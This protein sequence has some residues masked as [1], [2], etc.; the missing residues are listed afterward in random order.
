MKIL[1]VFLSLS[2]ASNEAKLDKL[3]DKVNAIIDAER[4]CAMPKNNAISNQLGAKRLEGWYFTNDPRRHGATCYKY[5]SGVSG[6]YNNQWPS[7]KACKDACMNLL[8]I[9]KSVLKGWKETI[10]KIQH[11]NFPEQFNKK[12]KSTIDK[13]HHS[14][15]KPRT[16][17]GTSYEGLHLGTEHLPE[18]SEPKEH[19]IYDKCLK[20]DRPE[21]KKC[22]KR[23]R[24]NKKS[25]EEKAAVLQKPDSTDPPSLI[26]KLEALADVTTTHDKIW[27]VDIV[28]NYLQDVPK[29][30]M[31]FNNIFSPRPVKDF[32]TV[33]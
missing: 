9:D 8:S 15:H 13:T 10:R 18:V 1:T 31:K 4:R 32:D 5:S 19:S 17:F 28:S 25:K 23:V 2:L 7:K 24:K 11:K 26:S 30:Q 27:P 6:Y 12:P 21:K 22:K 3:R 14:E 29:I 16:D 33:E 20:L